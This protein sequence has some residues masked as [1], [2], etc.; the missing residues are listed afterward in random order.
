MGSSPSADVFFGYD[1]GDL[2]NHETWESLKPQWW[3]DQDDSYSVDWRDEL[4]RRLGWAGDSYEAK[5]AV[6]ASIPVELDSYGYSEE[7]SWALRVTAS[8]QHVWDYGS[9]PLKPLEVD[10]ERVAQLARFVELL[11]LN[12]PEGGPGWHLNCSYG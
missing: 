3:Q 4:A 2:T 10:P 7:P 1:L 8:V 11:E 9:K 6:L 5:R 12:V